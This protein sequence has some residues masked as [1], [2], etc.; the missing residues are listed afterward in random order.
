[1]VFAVSGGHP[2]PAEVPV[3]IYSDATPFSTFDSFQGWYLVISWAREVKDRWLI[4]ALP[5]SAMC[6]CG[7]SGP[8][9]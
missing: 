3:T 4:A 6:R 7:C 9:A 2:V 1:L 8:E 5:K